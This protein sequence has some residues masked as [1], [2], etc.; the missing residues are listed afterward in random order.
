[1]DRLGGCNSLGIV[2][3]SQHGAHNATR[4]ATIIRSALI[5][6]DGAEYLLRTSKVE[7][8]NLDLLLGDVRDK[9]GAA[10]A[11]LQ[12]ATHDFTEVGE[13]P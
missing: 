6:L 11:A 2:I 9:L 4:A 5:L 7:F 1:M 8:N 12:W 3:R 13:K 10:E